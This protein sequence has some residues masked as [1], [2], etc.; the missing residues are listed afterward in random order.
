MATRKKKTPAAEQK[1][2]IE[3]ELGLPAINARMDAAA[4]GGLALQALG[5]G[6]AG[7]GDATD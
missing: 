7:G 3:E 1:R 5:Y 6:P 4:L 2:Y